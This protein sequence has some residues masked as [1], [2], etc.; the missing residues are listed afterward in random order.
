MCL[1]FV[2]G[3]LVCYGVGAPGLHGMAIARFFS[4]WGVKGKWEY[5]EHLLRRQ[6]FA[7]QTLDDTIPLERARPLDQTRYIWIA[8]VQM[9]TLYFRL[10]NYLLVV[11]IIVRKTDRFPIQSLS[12]GYYGPASMGQ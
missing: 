4:S 7:V 12:L 2:P 11:C 6:R 3:L 1:R 10:V 9:R 5:L 8:E